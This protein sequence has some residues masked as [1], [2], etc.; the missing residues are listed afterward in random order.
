MTILQPPPRV[1]G[2]ASRNELA[3]LKEY[4]DLKI[5]H[6]IPRGYFS[7]KK[8][9][10]FEEARRAQIAENLWIY[11]LSLDRAAIK[12]AVFHH[13]I[14]L[15]MQEIEA[16]HVD[17][18]FYASTEEGS[19]IGNPRWEACEDPSKQGDGSYMSHYLYTTEEEAALQEKKR[20]LRARIDDAMRQIAHLKAAVV[21]ISLSEEGWGM[22]EE[23][24]QNPKLIEEIKWSMPV[25]G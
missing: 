20:H 22:L 25:F 13:V 16:F 11:S 12:S 10:T 7:V 2:K 3:Q 19:F 17:Q 21:P 5:G 9:E 8:G 23:I 4:I 1:A 14:H 18:S 6:R 24:R 15:Y